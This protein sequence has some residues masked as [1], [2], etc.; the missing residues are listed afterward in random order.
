MRSS[1]LSCPVLI[2]TLL[3]T[4]K[5]CSWCMK[6]GLTNISLLIVLSFKLILY[7]VN[8]T[9]RPL[10]D[11]RFVEP[12]CVAVVVLCVIP[13]INDNHSFRIH[14]RIR[15]VGF[16]IL[17]LLNLFGFN[18]NF[19]SNLATLLFIADTGLLLFYHSVFLLIL[20]FSSLS[21]SVTRN[22]YKKT[23]MWWRL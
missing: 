2:P 19:V 8:G 16:W 14:K 3:R 22:H 18:V 9:L 13:S 11:I 20:P 5:P 15:G 7:L 12:I 6:K 1:P 17:L 21:L 10:Q 4:L 23:C